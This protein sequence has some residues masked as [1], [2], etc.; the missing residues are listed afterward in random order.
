M[1]EATAEETAEEIAEETWLAG[2]HSGARFFSTVS[3][4]CLICQMRLAVA[5]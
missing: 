1:E 4:A 2:L 5:D 3:V